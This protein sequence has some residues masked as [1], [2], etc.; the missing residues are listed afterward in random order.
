[1]QLPVLAARAP[2]AVDTS[3]GLRVLYADV[4]S[5]F[6]LFSLPTGKFL[7]SAWVQDE[8][9]NLFVLRA[10][11]HGTPHTLVTASNGVEAVEAFRQ[12]SFDLVLLDWVQ[13]RFVCISR[14]TSLSDIPAKIGHAQAHR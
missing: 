4:R 1:M 7:S 10:F 13:I 2:L 14:S 6:F 8:P 11:L 9:S 3:T 12:E 5:A